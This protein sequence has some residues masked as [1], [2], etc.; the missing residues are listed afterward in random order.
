[1][2]HFQNFNPLNF[3]LSP[4]VVGSGE[5]VPKTIGICVVKVMIRSEVVLKSVVVR[6]PPI[7][8]DNAKR[9]SQNSLSLFNKTFDDIHKE[10]QN[11]ETSKQAWLFFDNSFGNDPVFYVDFKADYW[12]DTQKRR[13]SYYK[14]NVHNIRVP[15]YTR[16]TW[17][18]ETGWQT[19]LWFVVR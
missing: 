8:I 13:S 17:Q 6:H 10:F 4:S 14:L 12:R 5:S 9:S 19:F 3:R 7:Q 11:F 2:W 15:T 18:I 1:M 16:I